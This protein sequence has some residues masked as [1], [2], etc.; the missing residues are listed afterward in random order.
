MTCTNEAGQQYLSCNGYAGNGRGLNNPDAQN[1]QNV[2]PLPQGRYVVGEP[3]NR[4]GPFTLP[5]IPGPGNNMFGRS[6]FLIHGDNAALNN[7]ASEGCIVA[8]RYCRSRIP[9]GEVLS[10]VP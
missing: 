4:R 8:P 9:S 5:L 10:V 6:G 2:G 1:Q 7:S 3:N